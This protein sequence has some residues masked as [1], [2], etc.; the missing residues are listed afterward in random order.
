MMAWYVISDVDYGY[1][2]LLGAAEHAYLLGAL[3]PPSTSTLWTIGM[4]IGMPI[5]LELC[6]H[7]QL[8]ASISSFDFG[9][10]VLATLHRG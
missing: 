8:P 1:A 6:F 10:Q 9:L 3:L 2:Y 7:L 5:Y 4:S